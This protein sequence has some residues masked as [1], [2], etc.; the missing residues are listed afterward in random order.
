MLRLGV[1]VLLVAGFLLSPLF[2]GRLYWLAPAVVLYGLGTAGLVA[3]IKD[4]ESRVI[5]AS[6]LVVFL[7]GVPLIYLLV[8]L[9]QIPMLALGLVPFRAHTYFVRSIFGALAGTGLVV[10]WNLKGTFQ[11]AAESSESWAGKRIDMW[12]WFWDGMSFRIAM[13]F[14]LAGLFAVPG[15]PKPAAL[16]ALGVAWGVVAAA[17]QLAYTVVAD[18]EPVRAGLPRIVVVEVVVVTC[19]LFG[20]LRGISGI[21]K[22][23]TIGQALEL[24]LPAA[25]TCAVTYG[26]VYL[27]ATVTAWL[28]AWRH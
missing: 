19:L 25:L 22:P 6:G 15:G 24:G 28:R 20:L 9:I 10:L 26:L 13:A 1:G 2:L 27:T 18:H 4:P 7:L 3:S 14:V 17:I 21:S 23:A 5:M 12:R 8:L 11:K 16:I